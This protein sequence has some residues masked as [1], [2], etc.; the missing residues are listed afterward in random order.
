MKVFVVGARGFPNVQGGMEKYCEEVYKRLSKYKDVKITGIVISKYYKQRFKKWQNINF[1]YV[2]SL[3]SK[4]LEKIFYGFIASIIIIIKRPDIVHFHGLSCALY[5][6]LIKLFGIKVI[7]TFQSRD[8]LYPKWGKFAKFVW[9]LSEKASFKSDIIIAVSHILMKHI[10]K[11]TDKVVYIPNGVSIEYINIPSEEED[12]YLSKYSLE[13][14]KYIFFA[15]R[16]TPEKAIEDLIN[17]YIQLGDIDYKLVIAGDADHEDNYS[18]WI[19]KLAQQSP[20]IILT[21]FITGKEFQTLF[22]NSKLFV[23]PSK[24]EGLPHVLLEALSFGVEVLASDIEANRQINLPEYNFFK[25]GNVNDLSQKILFF[26]NTNLSEVE[27]NR[28]IEM[29][30]KEYNWDKIAEDIYKQY[31]ILIENINEK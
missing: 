21:G 19:K 7:L 10:K 16:F 9:K 4:N 3:N 26:L 5:I 2:K 30:K 22:V 20:K 24:F 27:K 13:R 14:K 12:Q 29:V 15:G 18:R 25:V 8:Y 6:P 1:I 17:A 31:R 28:R 23:L 11:Y